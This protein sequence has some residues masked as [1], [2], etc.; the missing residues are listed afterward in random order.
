[1]QY[2][3]VLIS[4]VI[5]FA[6]SSLAWLLNFRNNPFKRSTAAFTNECKTTP[7]IAPSRWPKGATDVRARVW[8]IDVRASP[9]IIPTKLLS[10]LLPYYSAVQKRDYTGSENHHQNSWPR[11]E[12]LLDYDNDWLAKED[13]VSS[14]K[15]TWTQSSHLPR[16]QG[17][18][19]YIK[20]LQRP[21][22]TLSTN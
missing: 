5:Y 6:A 13:K 12:P 7:L 4:P 8:K 19:T 11:A 2:P 21:A 14:H 20:L 9:K 16:P 18:G 17:T 1:M 15:I 3:G 10:G 22:S